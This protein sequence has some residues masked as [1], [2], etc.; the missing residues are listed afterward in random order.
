MDK[1]VYV[2]VYLNSNYDNVNASSD[3]YATQEGAEKALQEERESLIED[4]EDWEIK[5]DYKNKFVISSFDYSEFVEVHIEE[6][7]IL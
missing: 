6:R 4:Y 5:D 1:K 7:T 2:L 3:V